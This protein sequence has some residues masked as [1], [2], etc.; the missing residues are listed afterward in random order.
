MPRTTASPRFRIPALAATAALALGALACGATSASAAPATPPPA[1]TAASPSADA[2]ATPQV[3]PNSFTKTSQGG[4]RTVDITIDDGPSPEWTPQVL[5]VLHDNGAHATFCMIGNNAKKY[6]SLVK[7]VAEAGNRLC[8][9]SVDHD[10]TMDHKSVAYQ[11]GE[12]LG[13]ENSIDAA[14]GG[15]AKAQYYR[16]PGGAFTPAS[17]AFAASH[18]LRPL[19]WNVDPKDWSRPGTDQIVSAVKEQLGNG[20]V[21]LFHDGGGNRSETVAALTQLLPWFTQHGYGFSFPSTTAP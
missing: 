16:A 2:A 3:I 18:G 15:V 20:P 4:P 14:A 8:D 19:G 10:M 21:V 17:R 1:A 7:E 9:H 5:K 12:I 13:G 11:Q 6:P